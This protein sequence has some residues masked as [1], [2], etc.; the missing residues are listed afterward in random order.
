MSKRFIV[1]FENKNSNKDFDD[2]FIDYI[3]NNNLYWWHWI[4]NLWLLIDPSNTLT[5]SIIRDQI[6]Q[7]FDTNRILVIELQEEK[8]TWSGYG[9]TK[10]KNMFDW[11][12][13]NWSNS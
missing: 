13:K 8:D 4:S 3:E 12:K 9:P 2:N 1:C 10:P 6:H 7:I 11:M 5:A